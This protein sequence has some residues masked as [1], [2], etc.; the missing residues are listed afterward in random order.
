[1]EK[2][3]SVIVPV[4]N[5]GEWVGETLDSL[6]GQTYQNLEVLCVDDGSSDNSAEIIR[7]YQNR[8]S[9]IRLIEKENGG[10]S[11]ARNLGIEEAKGEYIAF[12]DA[13]DYVELSAYKTMI[14]L[15]EKEQSDIT[16]CGFIRF[17]PN[18]KT[19]HTVEE[20][21]PKLAENPQDIKYFLLSTQSR[22]EENVLYTRDIHGSICRS[23]FR[24]EIIKTKH[25][26]LH[27]ELRFAED[28]IFM[29]EY[30]AHCTKG[31]YVPQPL[32]WYRGWTKPWVYRSM[33][34]NMMGL[35]RYQCRVLEANTFYSTKERKELAGYC[36]QAAFLAIINQELMF[37]PDAEKTLRQYY[38]NKEFVK[39]NS[40]YNFW[41]KQK[42]TRDV[43]RVVLF[44]LMKLRL[45][46]VVRK[47][48]PKKKY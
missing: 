45:F 16:F 26:R 17:W 2:L 8:D 32:L 30:L 7:K 47:T 15:L 21:L 42:H 20:N 24:S 34:E 35:Y 40:F 33:Y 27:G 11:S 10:V 41:Q 4:Y 36:K 12:L 48:F 29:L 3:L 18:E 22:M 14:D 6:L 23:V 38:K 5:A 9:R 25:I 37:K 44:V 31:S 46:A 28:Q 13:D 1:M 19:L 39:L 43:K